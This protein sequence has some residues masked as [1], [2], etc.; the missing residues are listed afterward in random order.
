MKNNR[1][2]A[3]Y[4]MVHPGGRPSELGSWGCPAGAAGPGE[5]NGPSVVSLLLP[6]V[7]FNSV[8][9]S[10]ALLLLTRSMA[11]LSSGECRPFSSELLGAGTGGCGARRRP[12][13]GV[14][15]ADAGDDA[16]GGNGAGR[17]G[18]LPL[19]S[20]VDDGDG[21]RSTLL[22]LFAVLLAVVFREVTEPLNDRSNRTLALLSEVILRLSRLLLLALALAPVLSLG[23]LLMWNLRWNAA[24][25][26]MLPCCEG[27]AVGRSHWV[28][29]A[30]WFT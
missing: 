20:D 16:D 2:F 6:P 1:P 24:A 8:L 23:S 14:S 5:L 18:R 28:V 7:S 29:R 27:T 25:D 9:L 30:M 13:V 21:D 4:C 12:L 10:L 17:I 19:E 3:A 26:S 15:L 11:L 22:L